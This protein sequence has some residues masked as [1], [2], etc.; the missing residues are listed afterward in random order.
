M[1]LARA[2]AE[3]SYLLDNIGGMHEYQAP[4]ETLH[5]R[6]FL[7]NMLCTRVIILE[8]ELIFVQYST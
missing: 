4:P 2:A 6:P 8:Y 1:R 3:I 5:L 7:H